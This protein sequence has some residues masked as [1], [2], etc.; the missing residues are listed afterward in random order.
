MRLCRNYASRFDEF[1]FNPRTPY[2]MRL[3][4]KKSQLKQKKDFNPRTPYGM[5]QNI[6]RSCDGLKCISIHA[7]LT[8]CDTYDI[9][10]W[11]ALVDFNPRTPYG[12]RPMCSSSLPLGI[13]ISIHAPLTGCDNGWWLD[14]HLPPTISIHAPLTGCDHV[15]LGT[16]QV[17]I[18][19]QSTHPLRDATFKLL[20][21]PFI[22]IISIHAPLTGCD[23][24][25]SFSMR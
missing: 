25:I 21:K 20:F 11:V 19:F 23:F 4:K 5:R 17:F 22:L 24:T 18:E 15:P 3:L 14:W 8:G 16:V 1:N 9:L 7:P 2:G 10:K 6:A 13:K 12:M